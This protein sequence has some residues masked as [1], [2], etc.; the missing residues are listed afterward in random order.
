MEITLRAVGTVRNGRTDA[1]DRGWGDVESTIEMEAEF[2]HALDG[3]AEQWSHAIV[4]FWMHRDPDGEAPPADWRRH[5]RGRADLPMLGV[6]A[7]RGRLRPN[8]LGVTAVRI[9]RGEPGRLVVRGL[10]AIDGTPV[11]DVKPYA[12]VFDRVDDA[13]VPVWFTEMMPGYF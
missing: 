5:P 2:A 13:R 12:P 1:A 9:V 4:V 10:D 6:F 3:L 7:Q 8:V 11:V